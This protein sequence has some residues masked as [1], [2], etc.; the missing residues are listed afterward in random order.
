MTSGVNGLSEIFS[1]PW[2]SFFFESPIRSFHLKMVRGQ[3]DKAVNLLAD[4]I[5]I[6]I[7]FC[8]IEFI[9]GTSR[10]KWNPMIIAGFDFFKLLHQT[11]LGV[12]VTLVARD[13]VVK[14]PL[15]DDAD[16]QVLKNLDRMGLFRFP[17]DRIESAKI[18]GILAIFDPHLEFEKIKEER[19]RVFRGEID[20][21][22]IDVI[23][24]IETVRLTDLFD[25]KQTTFDF[26][27]MWHRVF[28][29]HIKK[30]ADKFRD[31]MS[32]SDDLKIQVYMTSK[33]R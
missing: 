30:V 18:W 21:Y 1:N 15:I 24:L 26:I 2:V 4:V 27:N 23:E 10:K 20:V 29:L 17:K 12:D 31:V 3:L 14:L 22:P 25:F 9:K 19:S 8:Q 5:L 7:S 28:G 11:K 13:I 6:R 33:K 32:E 16:L